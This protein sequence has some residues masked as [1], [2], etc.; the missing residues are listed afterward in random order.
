MTPDLLEA[1][2]RAG[3]SFA[4]QKLFGLDLRGRNLAGASF[5]GLYGPVRWKPATFGK[6]RVADLT[7]LLLAPEQR[8]RAIAYVQQYVWA[9]QATEAYVLVG[10]SG[11]ARAWVNG[12]LVLTRFGDH[13]GRVEADKDKAPCRLRQGWNRVLVKLAAD[14]GDF[15]AQFRLVGLDRQPLPGLKFAATPETEQ[16]KE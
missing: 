10:H 2:V 12:E 8:E 5:A 3:R 13:K 14:G 11:H 16:N 15:K 6:G 9:G 7:K 1:A 4:G